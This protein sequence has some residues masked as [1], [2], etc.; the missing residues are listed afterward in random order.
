MSDKDTTNNIHTLAPVSLD[1]VLEE[2]AHWRENKPTPSAA[3]P[4]SLWCKICN[5]SPLKIDFTSKSHL[6]GD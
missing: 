3:M 1:A 4:D 5:Y 6:N 2:I